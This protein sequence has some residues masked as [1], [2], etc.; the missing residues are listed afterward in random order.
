MK[1]KDNARKCGDTFQ[2]NFPVSRV[3]RKVTKT[4]CARKSP[5]LKKKKKN[6]TY[7]LSNFIV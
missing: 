1:S 7:F 3:H 5:I 2:Q 4:T 6:Y